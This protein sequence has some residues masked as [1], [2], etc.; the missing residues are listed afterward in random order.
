MESLITHIKSEIEADSPDLSD[1]SDLAGNH[2]TEFER[3][4]KIHRD[5]VDTK[6]DPV[7]DLAGNHATEFERKLKL[8]RDQVNKEAD[9]VKDLAGNHVTELKRKLKLHQDRINAD[10]TIFVK[11]QSSTFTN[12]LQTF[13]LRVGRF[14]TIK[15][16]KDKIQQKIHLS[17][18]FLLPDK[19]RIVF[20]GKQLRNETTLYENNISDSSTVFCT[21]L[22]E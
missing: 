13:T 17:G 22:G 21:I 18:K 12:I 6:A 5:R 9:P 11:Q 16:V 8:H 4:L 14:A 19:I 7:E 20:A 10:I 3:K 15:T 2:A 1:S